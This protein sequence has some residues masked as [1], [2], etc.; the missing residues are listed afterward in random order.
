MK[1]EIVQVIDYGSHN[2][3]RVI[4]RVL[5]NCNLHFYIL[6]DTSFTDATHISNKLRHMHWFSNQ[7]VNQGDEVILYTK[8]GT[9]TSIPINGGARRHTVYWGLGNSV[10]NNTGDAA[11]LFEVN[12]WGTTPVRSN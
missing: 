3:E 11:I 12:R 5:E 6:T 2:S 7:E 9:N 10:W 4:L 1:I 8:S